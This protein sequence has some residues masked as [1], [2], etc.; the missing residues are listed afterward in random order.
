MIRAVSEAV[1]ASVPLAVLVNVVVAGWPWYFVGLS[2][3]RPVTAVDS[4]VGQAVYSSCRVVIAHQSLV[5]RGIMIIVFSRYQI[6][7]SVA[8]TV[9]V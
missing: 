1:R 8:I 3:S 6:N 4:T 7:V 5:P 9:V 2:G